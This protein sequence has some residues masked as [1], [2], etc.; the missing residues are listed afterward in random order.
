[1]NLPLIVKKDEPRIDSRVLAEQLGIEHESVMRLLSKYKADFEAQG[2]LRFQI[3]E[4]VGKGQ[5]QKYT[6]LN[7]DQCWL[8]LTYSRNTKKVRALKGQLVRAFREARLAA[9]L[10]A[11]YLPTYRAMHDQLT[12]F[13]EGSR[14]DRFLHMNINK[15]VNAAAG[16]E[17]G[18][19]ATAPMPRKALQIVAQHLAYKAMQGAT[20]GH[21]AYAA[22][23]S[24]VAPLS[25]TPLIGG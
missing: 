19:R 20:D 24:A 23:K 2:F 9:E 1:M 16:I 11:E 3:G 21:E 7:E 18:Q 10:K 13:H 25:A 14:K 6:Y 8:L 12:R 5:P 15:L 17:A 4:I 22:V